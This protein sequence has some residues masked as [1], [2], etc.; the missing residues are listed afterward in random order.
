MAVPR[1]FPY[2]ATRVR[3]TLEWATDLHESY[4]GR[5]TAIQVRPVPRQ[6]FVISCP[7]AARDTA[8]ASNLLTGFQDGD[9]ALPVW[10][11]AQA[12][13]TVSGTTLT[14]DTTNR[15]FRVGGLI[16]VWSSATQN[17]VAEIL[18]V[19]PG[20]LTL[21]QSLAT[22]NHA[23]VAPAR[24]AR[25]LGAISR[26]FGGHAWGLEANFR[27][28]DPMSWSPAAE[29]LYRGEDFLGT[30]PSETNRGR[31][32]GAFA[33]RRDIL[34][35][36]LGNL[37]EV[38]P[39]DQGKQQYPFQVLLQGAAEVWAFRKF[40]Y[41]MSGKHR[42]FWSPSWEAD[43]QPVGVLDSGLRL[44]VVDDGL[45]EASPTLRSISVRTTSGTWV[46]RAINE[47]QAVAG[48]PTQAD[49]VLDLGLGLGVSDIAFVS[50]LNLRRLTTDRVVLDWTGGGV[51]QVSL[52][53]QT[54]QGT[55]DG[56]PLPD[57]YLMLDGLVGG[58]GGSYP[59]VIDAGVGAWTT[60]PI[61][62]YEAI[63]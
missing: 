29:S 46:N 42:R 20:S 28:T 7:V 57:P 5:E 41:R 51:V 44:R 63:P 35:L 19:S 14:L 52:T 62:D 60:R 8:R 10:G 45:L 21:A 23:V 56:Q 22:Q 2:Q 4:D 12:A 31:A 47:I 26:D 58:L 38:N 11:E 18:T 9:W 33:V 39:W 30:R 24:R 1:L 3:E 32:R 48:V 16:V 43:L 40:L 50:W 49:L 59:R 6:E 36:S 53:A 61:Y 55:S 15:D 54:T 34:D 27:V 13:G 17:Q 37:S 25:G